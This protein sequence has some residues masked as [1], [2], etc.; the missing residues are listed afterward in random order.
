MPVLCLL[1]FGKRRRNM[2]HG[3]ADLNEAPQSQS[4]SASFLPSSRYSAV[5]HDLIG[6]PDR[7]TRRVCH[8]MKSQDL[9]KTKGKRLLYDG[10][11]FELPR[12]GVV[13]I[14]GANGVGKV[15]RWGQKTGRLLVANR[16]VS[17][18][19][20]QEHQLCRCC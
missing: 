18:S 13:G 7:V 5:R 9:G 6:R 17:E 10:V 11:N 14:I 15:Q 19:P 4:A 3:A 12:G 20:P 1:P 2:S 16:M 8:A